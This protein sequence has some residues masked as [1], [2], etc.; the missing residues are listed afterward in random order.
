MTPIQVIGI[1]LDGVA[2]VSPRL[3]PLIE[4]A[5]ILVGSDRHLSYF[6]NHSGQRWSL[7]EIE[8]RLQAHLNQ[9]A[10]AL[11]VIL[12]S[13]DPLFFGLGRRL[14][15]ALPAE[16]LTFHPHISSV[17]L[18]FNRAKL[19]WQDAA[20]ISVHGRS[21]ERLEQS[22]KQGQTPIAILTDPINTPRTI[23]RFVQSLE[24][25]VT[26]EMW[27]CENLGGQEE[28]VQRL[29]LEAAQQVTVSSLNVVILQLLESAP[30]L[31]AMP[32]L[33]IPDGA[34]LSFRDRPGL[35]TKREVRI[36]VLAELAL[37]PQNVIW[38]VGA[39][40]GSVSIEIARLVP[41]AQ[42]WAVEKTDVGCELIRRNANRFRVEN[43]TVVQGH[44]PD[45]L[46]HLPDPHRIFIGGSSGQLR[47]I[48]DVGTTR[49]H[50]V[51]RLV[52]ALAT[53]E[54]LSEVNQWL[55]SRDDWHGRY[56][57]ISLTRSAEVGTRNRWVPLNP[58]TLV[59]LTRK[60]SP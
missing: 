38:D 41:N 33:G 34:F 45:T 18:A 51:G 52:I 57:Q 10:P 4:Q 32:I 54:T 17:Q 48:L 15:Q 21:L 42:V 12:T 46:M 24:L 3:L 20:L 53:L 28:Q 56:Q 14:L 26:Y 25:P 6:P 49:L 2:G 58:V 50:H 44:A 29:S 55:Q 27:I 43:L 5:A 36:H 23:A 47:E 37:Q 31:A 30:Q 19:P 13:G 60:L 8:S 39:G 35:M 16:K 40:T 22:L 9:S 59:S 1:G 7:L 11:I